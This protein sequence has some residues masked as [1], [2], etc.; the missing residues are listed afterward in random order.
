METKHRLLTE[1][2]HFAFDVAKLG[3]KVA[4]IVAAFC[5]VKELHKIHKGIEAK[6]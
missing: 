1:G 5:A 6:K 2:V 4:A 3:L